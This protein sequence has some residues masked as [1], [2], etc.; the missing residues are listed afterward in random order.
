[1]RNED[2]LQLDRAVWDNPG[3]P[4]PGHG[5]VAETLNRLKNAP[6]AEWREELGQLNREVGLLRQEYRQKRVQLLN[7]GR[8]SA[9]G[10]YFTSLKELSQRYNRRI[11][12]KQREGRRLNQKIARFNA[13][14]RRLSMREQEWHRREMSKLKSL[15][16]E[17]DQ[18]IARRKRKLWTVP[19]WRFMYEYLALEDEMERRRRLMEEKEELLDLLEKHKRSDRIYEVDKEIA[20]LQEDTEKLQL[21]MKELVEEFFAS[22]EPSPGAAAAEEG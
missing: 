10:H 11:A 2:G 16:K 5:D 6:V 9:R 8:V 20:K 18:R 1:M 14:F 4:Y 3:T 12:G 7:R 13:T 17:R 19:R 22:R 15:A 21:K